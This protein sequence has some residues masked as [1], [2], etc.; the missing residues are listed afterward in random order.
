MQFIKIFFI[1]CYILIL[2]SCMAPVP[3]AEKKDDIYAKLFTV[4]NKKS[5]IYIFMSETYGGSLSD[6]L[7]TPIF[8][9][10][11][12]IGEITGKTYFKITTNPGTH[13]IVTLS[14]VP[15]GITIHTQANRNYFVWQ[16]IKM[17]VFNARVQFHLVSSEKGMKE[18]FHCKLI[19]HINK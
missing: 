6:P 17:G 5:N 19:K 8:F 1:F 3:L 2:N 7:K 14:E 12:N 10:S 9:D 18:I 16:K 4:E 15:A 13:H 11:K